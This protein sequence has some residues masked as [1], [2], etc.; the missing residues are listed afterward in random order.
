[1]KKKP[2]KIVQDFLRLKNWDG[3][4]IPRTDE[5]LNENISAY[6]ERLKWVSNFSGSFGITIILLLLI[7]LILLLHL[8]VNTAKNKL[9]HL[10][11]LQ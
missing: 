8:Q 7:Q 10:V 4:I 11:S 5:Y 1:M 2:I 9:K 6:A 3:L